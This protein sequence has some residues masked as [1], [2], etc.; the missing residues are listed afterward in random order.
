LTVLHHVVEGTGPLVVLSH[1]LGC[2]RSMWDEVAVQL[3]D[4]FTVVRHDHRGHGRSPAP[5]GAFTIHDLADDLA[6][7][8]RTLDRGPAHVVGL[9]M[10]GMAG[11]SLAARHP[12]VVRTLVIAN[13]AGHYD[14]AARAMW[15]ARVAMV[16]AQGM[17]AIAEGALQ[18][19]FTPAFRASSPER[20][21]ELR[22]QLEATDPDAY[23]RSC[24][25]VAAIDLLAD[26]ARVACPTLVIAGSRDEATPP[27]QSEAIAAAI[28]GARL[29]TID[30]AH[31]SAVEQ[32]QAFA[33]RLERFWS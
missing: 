30:A 28:P 33:Q 21:A 2:D 11:Q 32:P 5:P 27:A 9:S 24:E 26:D 12:A 31:L 4:R 3:R 8:I 1:A 18:R 29:A 15:A 22:R 13:S 14:D 16:R 23:A 7:L 17:A 20:L 25:A 10:G 6:A 19:W